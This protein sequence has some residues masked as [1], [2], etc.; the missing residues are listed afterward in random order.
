MVERKK[1]KNKKQEEKELESRLGRKIKMME[2]LLF[3]KK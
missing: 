1:S 2:T 3:D